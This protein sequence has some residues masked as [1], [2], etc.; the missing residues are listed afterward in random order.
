[1]PLW[2]AVPLTIPRRRSCSGRFPHGEHRS[3]GGVG[4][5][6]CPHNSQRFLVGG[7]SLAGAGR[8]QARA[9]ARRSAAESLDAD[10]AGEDPGCRWK[11]SRWLVSDGCWWVTGAGWY[12][13]GGRQSAG[14]IEFVFG[15][16]GAV[17]G[18]RRVGGRGG[19]ATAAR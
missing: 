3:P 16:A 1:M 2:L 4:V 5:F 12:V 10:R 9:A 11:G 13:Q 8:V 19:A 17:W 14:R 18:F 6:A 15:R 7:A